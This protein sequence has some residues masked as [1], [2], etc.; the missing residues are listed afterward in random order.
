MSQIA[1]KSVSTWVPTHATLADRTPNIMR[2]YKPLDATLEDRLTVRFLVGLFSAAGF[3]NEYLDEAR[4]RL[5]IDAAGD[6]DHGSTLRVEFV[7]FGTTETPWDGN[8]DEACS[9]IDR[10]A[11][12]LAA[13]I[14]WD[15]E[16][17]GPIGWERPKSNA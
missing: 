6:S 15:Q 9:I 7:G 1:I 14:R 4:K 10:S 8:G 5:T 3:G 11:E 13:D 2:Q 12:H 16:N 17:M